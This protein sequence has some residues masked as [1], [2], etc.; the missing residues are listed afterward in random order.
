MAQEEQFTLDGYA[1]NDGTNWDLIEFDFGVSRKRYEW[2]TGADA[3][4]SALVRDPLHENVEMTATLQASEQA[5]MTAALAQVAEIVAKLEECERHENGLAGVH[6]AADGTES[7]TARV[8]S[9]EV[10]GLPV[11]IDSGWFVKRPTIQIVMHRKPYWYGSEVGTVTDDFSTDTIANY[12]LDDGTGT[13]AITGG[14]LTVTSSPTGT[15]SLIRADKT[16]HDVQATVKHTTPTV[17]G[18]SYRAGVYLKRIDNQNSILVR[19]TETGAS[20]LVEIV[21][22]DGGSLTQ[23]RTTTPTA[24]TVSTAYWLL[25]RIEGDTITVEHWTSAPTATGSPATSLTYT[26]EG[27]DATQYGTGVPGS[28]GIYW[29]PFDTSATV[30]DF[31]FEPNVWKSSAPIVTGTLPGVAGDVPAEG[32]LIVTDAAGQSRRHLEWGLEQR[33]Y[34][35]GVPRILDTF[36]T[37]TITAGAYTFDT[38]SGTI[39]VAGGV[40]DP[41]DTTEKRFHR[42]D[43][44][45]WSDVLVT[46]KG[47]TGAAIAG[48]WGVTARR[49]DS[50]N[51]LQADQSGATIR[52]LK[53]DGGSLSTLTSAAITAASTGTAYW[54]RF[55]VEGNVLTAEWWTTD[56]AAGGSAANTATHTL[57]GADAVKFGTGIAGNV[58]VRTSGPG[59]DYSYDDFRIDPLAGA[60]DVL[61][62]SESLVYSDFAGTPTTRTGAHEGGTV[63]DHVI[64]G[65]LTTTPVAICGTGNQGHVGTF[66]VKARV[67]AAPVSDATAGDFHVRLSWKEGDGPLRSNAYVSPVQTGA[68]V[69]VDL[70]IVSIPEKTLGTQRWQGQIEAYSEDAGDTLDVDYLV[71]I[72]AGEGFGRAR[73]PWV[74]D[75]VTAF[76]A[77]DEF[78]QS[79]GNL[80]TKALPVGGT[81]ATSGSAT[82]LAVETTGKTAQRSAVGDAGTGRFAIASLAAFAAQTV[83]VDVKFTGT[84][85]TPDFHAGVIARYTGATSWLRAMVELDGGFT[86]DHN[87]A[88][89]LTTLATLDVW[90]LPASSTWYTIRLTVLADGTWA[91]WFFTTEGVA[92]SPIATGYSSALATGG[93]LDDGQVG[94]YDLGQAASGSVTRNYD[95]FVAAVPAAQAVAFSG[96]SAE[97]RHDSAIREDSAGTYWGPVPSYRGSRF[98]LPPAGDEDRSSQIVVKARRND[99]DVA[100]DDQIADSTTVAVTYTPRYLT[101]R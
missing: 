101:P 40:L 62:D 98:L 52:I 68:W 63:T 12:T 56:P 60:T 11:T 21:K 13:L 93:A 48:S 2:V 5:S 31:T 87:V 84:S 4:G 75:T 9:G 46:L 86:V 6:I 95:N 16:T 36:A 22:E 78:D 14:V 3:D 7:N 88:G 97:I 77:R 99:V 32:R 41:S 51:M 25:G 23:L 30:D 96:Q 74:Y 47:T 59:A 90:P 76:S 58:G 81:W 18:S 8:L 70:G 29:V 100:A 28:P 45:A 67:W 80:N 73:A 65:T 85:G 71:L 64:R 35:A 72:P 82:D 39:S 54:I 42:N 43:S 26:L 37:G 17:F 92:G 55:R 50:A 15:K 94:F 27:A 91:V 38:G 53:R 79:A 34:S 69:E 57:T 61:L 44:A 49:I 24:L 83:Q 89:S 66:R 33:H 1:F 19:V 10:V 20:R